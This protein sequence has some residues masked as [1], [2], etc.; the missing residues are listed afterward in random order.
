MRKLIFSALLA[1]AMAGCSTAT[2]TGGGNDAAVTA[3]GIELMR[4]T[5][6]FEYESYDTPDDMLKDVDMALIGEVISVDLAFEDMEPEPSG[7]V[8]VRLRPT[9]VWKNGPSRS[10]D[11]YYYFYRP[12][13]VGVDPYRKA[14]SEGTR[15]VLFGNDATADPP[16]DGEGHDAEPVEF[17]ES[18]VEFDTIYSAN[19]QGLFIETP[20][21]RLVNVWGAR[22]RVQSLEDFRRWR[23]A[24]LA[25][26]VAA[27]S[28]RLTATSNGN[29]GV[30][31][32]RWCAVRRR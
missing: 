1:T 3:D 29:T 10:G 15:V 24:E 30:S 19:P 14:L 12:N 22:H 31:D 13:N 6:S 20:E 28:L 18:N 5:V 23:S 9:E 32:E 11:V 17:A 8:I 4:D 27:G 7:V 25:W 21:D 2:G 26:P 16:P